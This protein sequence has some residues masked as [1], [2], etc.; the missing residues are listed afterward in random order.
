MKK[1]KGVPIELGGVRSYIL[2]EKTENI[3]K[4]NQSGE[5]HQLADIKKLPPIALICKV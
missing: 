3:S 1:V 2:E 5:L 4:S